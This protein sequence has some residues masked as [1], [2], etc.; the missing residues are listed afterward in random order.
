MQGLTTQE[1][2]RRLGVKV[3]TLY[4]YVSR[5]LVVRE[6]S[7]DGRTSSYDP[8]A[9]EALARR[10]RPRQSSRSTSL[11]MLIETG[12]T[13]LSPQGVRY[14]GRWSSELAVT[15]SFEEVAE[16][17][18]LGTGVT[19]ARPPHERWIGEPLGLPAAA[20]GADLVGQ[21]RI[22]AAVASAHLP[23]AG[24]L[25]A[26]SVAVAGRRLIASITDALPVA[27]D[28]RV[29]RLV[30]PA[31]ARPIA[32]SIAGRLWTRLS[33]RRPQPGMLAVLNAALVLMADHELAASTLAV[34]VAAST[35]ADPAAA[36]T[37]GLGVLSGPL[38]GGASIAA[39]SMLMRAG[40]VGAVRAVAEILDAG[41]RIPGF[42]HSVYVEADPRAVV[43]L[44]LLREVGGR[45]RVVTVVDDVHEAVGRRIDQ[46]ANVDFALAAMTMVGE[47]PAEGGEVVMSVARMAGWLAHTIEEYGETPLRFR[48]RASYVGP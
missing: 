36:V 19:T 47:M 46:A 38:H 16:L 35:R 6:R 29:P 22:A 37:T 41:R 10:G 17:L 4:A 12:I 24:G 13:A 48:P 9:I 32:G 44:R 27:G 42:G 33:P 8:R 40:E 30:L 5:G 2:A 25:D 31:P 34:R 15:H 3:E 1:A 7:A 18:W 21:L 26:A 28:G 45:S 11:N 14:R 23:P 20:E 43:L 39:R